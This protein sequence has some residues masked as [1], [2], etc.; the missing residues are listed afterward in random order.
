LLVPYD[1]KD[2]YNREEEPSAQPGMVVGGNTRT[3]NR[4]GETQ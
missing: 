2:T 1:H 3:A 4:I